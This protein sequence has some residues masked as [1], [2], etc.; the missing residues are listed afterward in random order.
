[1]TIVIKLTICINRQTIPSRGHL[2]WYSLEKKGKGK[3]QGSLLL[4]LSFGSEKNKQVAA[5]EYRHL[6]RVLLAYQ[7]NI[8]MVILSFSN[9]VKSEINLN[10]ILARRLF[11]DGR[12]FPRVEF[13]YSTTHSPK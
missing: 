6:L 13:N 9:L 10:L 5:Q 11:V 4:K 3:P 12:L 1:M 2:A 7:M 8:E